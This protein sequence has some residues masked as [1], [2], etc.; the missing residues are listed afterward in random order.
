MTRCF[1]TFLTK[2]TTN[3]IPPQPFEIIPTPRGLPIVGTTLSLIAAGSASKLHIYID[4]RHKQLGNIFKDKIGPINAVFTSDPSVMRSVFA[5]EGKYP[6]HVLPDAW[7]L[8]NDLHGCSRGLFFMDGEEWLHF[9]RIMNGLLLKGD[10]SYIERGCEI[11]CEE[12][13][14]TILFNCNPLMED[15]EGTLYR[16]SLNVLTA[17]LMGAEDYSRS[18]AELDEQLKHL[19]STVKLVFSTS[20]SLQI[21]P[22]GFAAKYKLGVW[23]NF[24]EAVDNALR[25][26]SCLVEELLNR[27]PGKSGL[28]YKMLEQ[29]IK[30]SDVT[31]IVTDLVI[32]AGDTSAYTMQWMLYLMSK[33]KEL[34]KEIRENRDSNFSRNVIKETLRLYPVAPFIT[35]FIPEDCIIANYKIPKSTLVILSLY[36]CGRDPKFFEEPN[37][38]LPKRW[39]RDYRE[40]LNTVQQASI[41]FAI[42]ARS[43]VGRKIAECQL[44]LA[45][46][47]ILRKFEIELKNTEEVEMVLKMV[48]VPSRKILIEFREIC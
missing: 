28:L 5:Q 18:K 14:D 25:A 22:A 17:I 31:R 16:W 45:L 27:Q 34:Q 13:V 43:C 23:K 36:T 10:L 42:G 3:S 38:F 2:Y 33:H 8:Y 1:R 12:L 11:A 47:K 7:R 9:R 48:G 40:K 46:E 29:N 41:P 37:T 32:A 26:S 39:Q 20:V 21:L 35:R 4:K 6:T 44:Q 30:R 24:E 19:A 15:L